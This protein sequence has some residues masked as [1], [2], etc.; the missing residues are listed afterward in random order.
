MLYE[1][2]LSVPS[3]NATLKIGNDLNFPT[4][5]HGSFELIIA[6]SGE[7]EITI[8]ENKYTISGNECVLVF[9]NQAHEIKTPS[10]SSHAILIFPPQLV[11]AFSKNYEDCIPKNNKFCLD[12]F[13]INKIAGKCCNDSIVELKGLLYTI[14]GEFNKTAEYVK[15]K[16]D[17]YLLFKIFNF[18]SENYK[19]EC[20][21]Y[22]LAKEINYTYVYL[23]QYFSKA[24]GMKYTEYVCH[25]RINEACYLL[26]N[27]N[28]T[29]LDIACECGFDC[30][31]S[32]NRNFKSI[33]GTTPTKYRDQNTYKQH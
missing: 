15:S 29:V 13:Y 11:R 10:H 23:S 6:T 30:L 24:T 26:M 5:I 9:P 7:L 19:S 12:S 1:A 3:D 4:H 33:M 21:L 18:I 20:S 14:C 28:H 32:F 22:D 25:F 27:T 31:R 16:N 8:K 17:S 2:D